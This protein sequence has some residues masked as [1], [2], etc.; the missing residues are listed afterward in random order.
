LG[1]FASDF[2][3]RAA[4]AALRTFFLAASRCFSVAMVAPKSGSDADGV[5]IAASRIRDP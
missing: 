5:P 4:F 2:C 3:S 1:I